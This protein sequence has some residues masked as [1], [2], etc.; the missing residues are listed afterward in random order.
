MHRSM[1]TLYS[2]SSFLVLAAMQSRLSK[3]LPSFDPSVIRLHSQLTS[4]IHLCPTK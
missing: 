1:R 2:L 4:V 3:L